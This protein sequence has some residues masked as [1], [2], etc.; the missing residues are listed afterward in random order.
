MSVSQA[1][2]SEVIDGEIDFSKLLFD[3]LNFY[4][5]LL[6]FENN[7]F[8]FIVDNLSFKEKSGFESKILTGRFL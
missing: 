2:K 4:A 6:Q 3:S 8:Y 7:I 1:I 5:T